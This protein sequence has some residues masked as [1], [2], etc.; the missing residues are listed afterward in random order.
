MVN[1]GWLVGWLA[2]WFIPAFMVHTVHGPPNAVLL[3]PES[4]VGWLVGGWFGQLAGWLVGGRLVN[5]VGGW[6][7]GMVRKK[8]CVYVRRWW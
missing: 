8:R 2:G 7:G 3:C 6:F 5:L 1:V 4:L